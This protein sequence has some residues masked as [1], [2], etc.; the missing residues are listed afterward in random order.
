MRTRTL[1][2]VA[3]LPLMLLGTSAALAVQGQDVNKLDKKE[4][5]VL[6]VEMH[7]GK[8]KLKEKQTTPFRTQAGG[9]VSWVV[10]GYCPAQNGVAQRIGIDKAS[11]TKNNTTTKFDPFDA[12]A[13]VLEVD[14]PT[15]PFGPWS[16]LV[17][18]IKPESEIPAAVKGHYKYKIKI[19]KADAEHRS[20]ADDGDFFLCPIWPCELQ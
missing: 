20:P 9:E 5:A 14:V 1:R 18:K 7:N 8:C 17:G 6:V 11:F 10:V 15:S 16:R 3:V 12:N 19:N 2:H 4:W 13:S